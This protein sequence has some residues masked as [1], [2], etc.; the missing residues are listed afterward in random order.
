MKAIVIREFGGPEV[1]KCVEKEKPTISDHQVLIRVKALSV[2]Y[3]DVRTRLGK[4]HAAGK[5]PIIPGLDASGIVEAVGAS[6]KSHNVG[7]RVIAFPKTGAY[8]E[9]VVADEDL[10]FAIPENLDPDGAAACPIVGFTAYMLLANVARLQPGESVLIH[11]A[12]GG[13]G[14]TA[15]QMAKTLGA[16]RVIGIVGTSQK[17]EIALEAGADQ[18]ICRNNTDFVQEVHSATSGQGVD[19]I[20]DPIAGKVAEKNLECLAP[21]GRLVA[22]GFASGEPGHFKTSDL[23]STCRSVMG[24]SIGTARNKRPQLLRNAAE[25]VFR[26]LSDG[27][28]KMKIS[29]IFPLEE[30]S[31]AHKWLEGPQ[32]TG[33]IL[34]KIGH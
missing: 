22:F 11:S 29:R 31:E 10:T 24:F 15:I 17:A 5:P 2:N 21:F 1:L 3:A 30:A 23:H 12:S 7:Q 13:V 28:I 19:V 27:Q 32:S 18:V 8:A 14:T 34:L 4:Y 20:L 26:Y 9:Y 6:V 16:S 33:K 25:N